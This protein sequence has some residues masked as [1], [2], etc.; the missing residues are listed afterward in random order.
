MAAVTRI[1]QGAEYM[2]GHWIDVMATAMMPATAI[3]RMLSPEEVGKL[4]RRIERDIPK[5]PM[6]TP[7]K[8]RA[9]PSQNRG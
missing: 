3:G 2:E 7:V 5:R 9:A 4:V 6:A 1:D 8:R